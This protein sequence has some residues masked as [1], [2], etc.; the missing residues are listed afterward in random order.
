LTPLQLGLLAVLGGLVIAPAYL[1]ERPPYLIPVGLALLIGAT[2]RMHPRHAFYAGFLA[3]MTLYLATLNWLANLFGPAMVPLCAILALFIGLYA[4]LT[5]WLHRRLPGIPLWVVAPMVWVAVEWYR[6]EPFVLRFGWIAPSYGVAHV[7]AFGTMASVVG[8][9]GVSFV[10]VMLAAALV[11]L[12]PK[13]RLGAVGLVAVWMAAF[14]V[15]AG[16]LRFARSDVMARPMRVRL[17]QANCEDTPEMVAQSR[18]GAGM[19]AEVTLW[20][21]YSFLSDPMRD[22]T[23]WR[24][25]R[26]VAREN[27]TWLIFGGKDQ[28]D[29]ANP[30]RYRNTAYVLAPDGRLIG[31]HVKVHTV[32]FINDGV[33]AAR[34]RAIPTGLGRIGVGICFDMDYPDVARRLVEDGAEVFLVP[35]MDPLEWGPI[36]REQHRAMFAMRAAECGRWLAR[37]DVAGGTSVYAPMGKEVARVHTSEPTRLDAQVGRLAHRT[38]YVRYGWMLPR[39]CVAGT[40]VLIGAAL[41]ADRRRRP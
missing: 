13:R 27:G 34:V 2:A 6:S 16:L 23:T 36:Q 12:W 10:I 11:A 7:P 24:K 25:L 31:R 28:F 19:R 38:P 33:A 18:I 22:A 29:R 32:H 3:G 30:D 37:A 35:N 17:V 39:L 20:P 41:L 14:A 26:A 9:Y 5:A 21:E 40:L 4:A 1:P 8:S 15:P